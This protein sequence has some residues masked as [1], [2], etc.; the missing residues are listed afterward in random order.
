MVS[1]SML[2]SFKVLIISVG[3]LE[4]EYYFTVPEG[5]AEYILEVVCKSV[6]DGF[7]IKDGVMVR[8]LFNNV[9]VFFFK[10][11]SLSSEKGVFRLMTMR[12]S[13]LTN[14]LN[15]IIILEFTQNRGNTHNERIQLKTKLTPFEKR[16][17]YVA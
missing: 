11:K 1:C 5:E 15:Y 14:H 9:P 13:S 10:T 17:Q 7:K 16:C 2:V 8:E 3:T 4:I 12:I 6:G